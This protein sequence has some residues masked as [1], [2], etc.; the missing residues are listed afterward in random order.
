MAHTVFEALTGDHPEAKG[1]ALIISNDYKGVQDGSLRYLQGA[2]SDSKEIAASFLF[3]KFVVHHIHNKPL[4]ALMD[5]LHAASRHHYPKT[6]KRLAIVFSGHGTKGHVYARDGTSLKLEDMF[7]FFSNSQVSHLRDVV[8]MFFIDACQGHERNVGVMVP[9]GGEL[10][11]TKLVPHGAN[12]LV[13]YSTIEN[14]MSYETV[15]GGMW[16]SR[17]AQ[18]LRTNS[19][20]CD[21]LTNINSELIEM[22]N[23]SQRQI[24]EIQ[25]PTFHSQ[26][27][28]IVNLYSEARGPVSN[29]ASS[30]PA[31]AQFGITSK[32]PDSAGAKCARRKRVSS[33]TVAPH[34]SPTLQA[35]W[36]KIPGMIMTGGKM[37]P[38][39][40][41]SPADS[42]TAATTPTTPTTST[43]RNKAKK[44]QREQAITGD[45]TKSSGKVAIL[46]GKTMKEKLEFYITGTHR[47]PKPTY[48]I[49]KVGKGAY[50]ATVYAA[51]IGRVTGPTRRSK[52]MAEEA[53]AA[54][55]LK[56]I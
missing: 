34:Q 12:T 20:I 44:V 47:R 22:Y 32:K 19:S 46:L 15:K 56:K 49:N 18:K 31:I 9:R 26:L 21:I 5:T 51:K 2:E 48:K 3:L 33:S 45:T 38:I 29:S 13:A 10:A 52:E 17:L 54:E 55:M 8:K 41:S 30:S 24:L 28:E 36:D 23:R 42:T 1:L 35:A 14:Y 50:E 25:Q 6:Y 4:G 39:I 37:P 16:M 43:I 7:E 40:P 53:A 27:N 11:M